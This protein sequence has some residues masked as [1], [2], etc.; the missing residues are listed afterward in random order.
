MELATPQFD[1]TRPRSPVTV[2]RFDRLEMFSSPQRGKMLS[3]PARVSPR[4]VHPDFAASKI[5][6]DVVVTLS[7]LQKHSTNHVRCNFRFPKTRASDV[8]SNF[9]HSKM[10]PHDDQTD[11]L[12]PKIAAN[13]VRSVFLLQQLP[14]TTSKLFLFT[15]LH[16][17]DRG[18]WSEVEIYIAKH[19]EARFTHGY[20]PAC[21]K[22]IFPI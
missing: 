8:G 16:E 22:S 17:S 20:Y 14:S 7:R 5:A 1:S 6:P 18:R 10:W 2:P 15:I 19:S 13:D 3:R 11:F 4:H 9:S 21:I 12:L